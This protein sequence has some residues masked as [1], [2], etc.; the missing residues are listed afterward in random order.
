MM[1]P[2]MPKFSNSSGSLTPIYIQPTAP[3]IPT[4]NVEDLK[5]VNIN[6][7]N[8]YFFF[9]I[10]LFHRYKTCSQIWIKKQ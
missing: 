7:N 4:L 1:L 8:E 9:N 10:V 6:N 2:Q 5:Q 3:Q